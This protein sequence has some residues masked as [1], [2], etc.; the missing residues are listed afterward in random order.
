[1]ISPSEGM[2]SPAS[3]TTQS[4]LARADA[5]TRLSVPSGSRIR[6]SV[7]DRILRRVSAWA[8]PRPSAMASA[9]LANP[10]VRNSQMVMDQSKI[11]GWAMASMRVT[12][13]PTRTTNM[14]GFFT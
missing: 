12:T 6:A 8:L 5:A 2:A 1:M 3:H 14:T 4:P 13:E 10:T 11:P 9:K 7:S